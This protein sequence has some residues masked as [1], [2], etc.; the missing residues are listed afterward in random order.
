MIFDN[1]FRDLDAAASAALLSC[2]IC[3]EKGNTPK[4]A[5][6]LSGCLRT[7]QS[8]ARRIAQATKDSLM[9]IDEDEYIESFKPQMMDVVYN[10]INGKSFSEI[11]GENSELF[12]GE[13][14]F[15]T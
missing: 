15:S 3:Q 11:C 8:F 6:V 12:E 2:F 4:L 14:F 9:E 13:Y 7:M 10:W 5:E 1:V